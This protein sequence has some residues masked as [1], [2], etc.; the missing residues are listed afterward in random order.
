LLA[1]GTVTTS[2]TASA[3]YAC[4]PTLTSLAAGNSLGLTLNITSGGT[5]DDTVSMQSI[6]FEYT[7]TE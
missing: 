6:A 7:A 5:P 1:A 4:T 3:V 2:G